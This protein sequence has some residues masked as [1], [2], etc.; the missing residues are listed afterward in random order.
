MLVKLDENIPT[1]L[2]E[3]LSAM[4]HDVD[5]V[6]AEGL[7]GAADASVWESAQTASRFL[8]T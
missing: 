1:T 8:V 4:G 3:P 2:K 6:S 7:I 5:T